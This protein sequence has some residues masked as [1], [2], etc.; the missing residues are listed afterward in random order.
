MPGQDEGQ[1][2]RERE[3]WLRWS[4]LNQEWLPNLHQP[5]YGD[6]AIVLRSTSAVIGAVGLVPLLAPFCQIPEL[7][8]DG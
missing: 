7:R 8:D 5:P 6:R 2:Q 3:S 1:A 4:I